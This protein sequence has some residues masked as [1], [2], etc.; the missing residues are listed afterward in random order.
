MQFVLPPLQQNSI[1]YA[2]CVIGHQR[3]HG[4]VTNH[5]GYCCYHGPCHLMYQLLKCVHRTFPIIRVSSAKTVCY[6]SRQHRLNNESPHFDSKFTLSYT[7][8]VRDIKVNE[9]N[10]HVLSFPLSSVID[11]QEDQNDWHAALSIYHQGILALYHSYDFIKKRP[12]IFRSWIQAVK[13]KRRIE[14]IL[15]REDKSR[16]HM[17]CVLAIHKLLCFYAE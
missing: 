6:R 1:E 13:K 4:A 8:A 5:K 2:E 17:M 15:I 9:I 11:L 3:C 12:S 10:I 7:S 16:G 14:K